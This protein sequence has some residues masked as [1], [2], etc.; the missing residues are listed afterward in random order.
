MLGLRGLFVIAATC[1]AFLTTVTNAQQ[2]EWEPGTNP[3]SQCCGTDRWPMERGMMGGMGGMTGSMPRH[4]EAMVSGVPAPYEGT[5]N[6]LPRTRETLDRG[7]TIYVENCAS[8]HG[9]TGRGDGEAAR[10][11]SPPPAD[12]AWLSRMPM[13]RWDP[14]MYWAVAE[15]GALFG[16]AMPAFKDTLSG[17]EI[18]AVIAYIQARLPQSANPAP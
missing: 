4:R 7:A 1:A 16:T 14:F 3:W 17:D 5:A 15:G 12:L 8:C 6:P 10:D 9:P 18:W 2:T 13:V 11:L